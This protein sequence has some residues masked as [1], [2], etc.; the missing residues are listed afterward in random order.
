MKAWP[1]IVAGVVAGVLVSCGG[2]GG[3][4][5]GT[6]TNAAAYAVRNLVADVSGSPY[7]GQNVDRNLINGWGI[8]FNPQGF[9]WVS[10][11]ETNKSTLYDG[12]GVPQSLVVSIPAGQNG[13]A[14]PTGIVFNGSSDFVVTQGGV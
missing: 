6:P 2:G 12:N 11:N 3:G 1:W 8:A 5:G 4:G 7:S 13:E 14:H 10:D 9:V